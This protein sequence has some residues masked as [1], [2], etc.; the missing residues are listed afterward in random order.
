[1]NFDVVETI[2]ISIFFAVL[3]IVLGVLYTEH[4]M[5]TIKKEAVEYGYADWKVIDNATGQSVF[6]WKK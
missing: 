6:V 4:N 5:K 2:C 1:M 3:G